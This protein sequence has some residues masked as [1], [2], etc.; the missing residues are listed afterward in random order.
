MEAGFRAE[1]IWIDGAEGEQRV[2]SK[3]KFFRSDPELNDDGMM[4]LPEWGFD[5]S[6]T[7]QAEGGSSD[8]I[9]K[10][11]C[12][13]PDPLRGGNDVLVL[14]EVFNPDGNTPHPSN[15]RAA[16]RK[17]IKLP[18]VVA[19]EPL[20]GIEQEYTMLTRA[21]RPLGFPTEGFPA[22]Q[23]PYYCGV[24]ADRVFGR[25]LV[26]RHAEACLNAGL[27]IEGTNLEVM[28]GQ[29]EFQ[30]GTGGPLQVADHL[31]IARW[32][33]HRI[34]EDLGIVVSLDAKP[35]PDWNG[36]GGHLNVSTNSMRGEY[37][38]ETQSAGLEAIF[39][40]CEKMGTRIPEH[41]DVYGTDNHLRLTGKHE[42]CDINT[43]RYNVG[44]R[45]AS[46][47]IPHHVASKGFGYLEDRRPAA[48]ANP[49]LTCAVVLKTIC[50]LWD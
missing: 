43:F 36:A 32:L 41:L 48:N 37:L 34:G 13:V 24:G 46:I 15:H 33:L 8:C 3:T 9:L 7:N 29:A 11:A 27:M 28:P 16:L 10:P 23:G 17:L 2:R 45:G 19:A 26:E 38:S 49:Y 20:F 35:H 30:I 31:W 12:V 42:T 1:Y 39:E 40:A 4:T 44:D 5:G 25:D 22:P 18:E 14:C 21:G 47:R 6:S 50:D